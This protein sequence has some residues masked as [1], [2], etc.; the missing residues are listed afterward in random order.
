MILPTAVQRTVTAEAGTAEITDIS[1]VAVGGHDVYR[2][3][4][5]NP[6]ANP[7]L[8]VA[9]DGTLASKDLYSSAGAPGALGGVSGGSEP[10]P[11]MP[12]AVLKALQQAAPDAVVA[13]VHI[14]QHTIYEITFQDPATHPP[15]LITEDGLRVRPY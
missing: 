5:R 4:F 14:S 3:Q 10:P 1:K 8:Y 15:I 7:T 6:E 2:I 13:S 12:P 9:D 11:S